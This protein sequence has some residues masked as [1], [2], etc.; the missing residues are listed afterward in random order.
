MPLPDHKSSD[1]LQEGIRLLGKN[2]AAAAEQKFR[3]LLAT[4]QNSTPALSNLAIALAQQGKMDEAAG[5]FKKIVA[6]QPENDDAHFNLGV[7]FEKQN[8]LTEAEA[9]LKK[10]LSLKPAHYGARMN[11]GAIYRR[12]GRPSKASDYFQQA[13]AINP[14]SPDG[15][16]NLGSAFKDQGFLELAVT[17]F[18]KALFFSPEDVEILCSLATT[19]NLLNNR[20]EALIHLDKALDIDPNNFTVQSTY[21]DCLEFQNKYE[22]ALPFLLRANKLNPAHTG[23]YQKLAHVSLM[24]GDPLKAENY[25]RKAIDCEPDRWECHLMLG[26]FFDEQGRLKEAEDCYEKVLEL[27]PG[28]RGVLLNIGTFFQKYNN[29]TKAENLFRKALD[30]SPDYDDALINLAENLRLQDRL[31]EAASYTEDA[32]LFLEEDITR[33]QGHTASFHKLAQIYTTLGN[34]DRAEETLRQAIEITPDRWDTYL[35]LGGLLEEHGRLTEAESCCKKILELSPN[36][37]AAINNLGAIYQKCNNFSQAEKLFRK[38]LDILP[39]YYDALTNLA[40]NLRIQGR[41]DE[42]ASFL[43]KAR[44]LNKQSGLEIRSAIMS[45]VIYQNQDEIENW[46]DRSSK[47]I[48]SLLKNP[49]KFGDPN[50]NLIQPAF[51]LAYH[52][53]N[54]LRIMSDLARLAEIVYPDL[55]YTAP[56]CLKKTI[57]NKSGKL[58]IAFISR[59]FYN[60]T[61]SKLSKGII[62]N[63][64]RAKFEVSVG[65][66]ERTDE[67]KTY[68][69]QNAADHFFGLPRSITMARKILTEKAFDIIFYP[70]IGME[71]STYC[72]AFSRL[73]PVQ[74]VT[75]GHPD[76]T[77]I[78]TIDHYISCKDLE[79][80]GADEHYS[81]NLVLLNNL[82]MYYFR[83]I[84]PEDAI[85]TKNYFK[86][87]E[88]KNLYLCPQ[89][90]F[91]FHPDFDALLAGILRKDSNGLIILIRQPPEHYSSLLESRWQKSIPDIIHRIRFVPQL[92][93]KDFL[94]L[95]RVCD[96]MLD[97]IHFGG[98]NT[99]FEGL[100]M[101]I[102]IVTLPGQF[103][104]SRVAYACYKQMGFMDCVAET[105]EQYVNISVRLGTDPDYRQ[106][107]RDKITKQCGILFENSAAVRELEKF[108]FAAHQQAQERYQ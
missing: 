104:R 24:T 38:V 93:A 37:P 71:K 100:A 69:I 60:H 44:S 31:D 98:G 103:M 75:W 107:I 82:P 101:G 52:G 11:L 33:N 68:L 50:F 87:P 5:Y 12:Q 18:K 108:F 80:T 83:P 47:M 89:T 45:P 73:A 20:Q 4:E 86:L 48:T 26:G 58:R 3:S 74:C 57:Q 67:K 15:Y 78:P 99:N 28:E 23:T 36:E 91:K 95:Q 19:Q 46:R 77:G 81:E 64:S 9:C 25:L 62:E 59:H 92:S 49:P 43:D 106:T 96:V 65:I 34:I 29:F 102:P 72:L 41:T 54:D 61:I 6:I 17:S 76:T 13:L 35:K 63:L 66:C 30:L 84:L 16:F 32:I 53:K 8:E 51:F 88:D 42:A 39:G 79:P 14:E 55:R 7:L 70:D 2:Q 85:R 97:S 90:L 21:G 10:T 40:E 94:A 1:L 22:D 27:C 56:H 105:P